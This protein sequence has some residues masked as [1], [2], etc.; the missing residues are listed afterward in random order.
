MSKRFGADLICRDIVM[1]KY[2]SMYVP[3][4]SS[5]STELTLEHKYTY[6]VCACVNICAVLHEYMYETYIHAHA[7]IFL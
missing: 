2:I 4:Y 7:H 3:M 5:Y 6:P 1:H